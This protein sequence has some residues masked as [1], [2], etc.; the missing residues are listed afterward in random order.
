[1]RMATC[2]NCGSDLTD[3]EQVTMV[4]TLKNPL[5]RIHPY[6]EF[7]RT[8]CLKCV[9]KN[10]IVKDIKSKKERLKEGRPI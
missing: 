9:A 4:V 1:M 8:Y 2:A 3:K 6:K 5:S 7:C 10:V